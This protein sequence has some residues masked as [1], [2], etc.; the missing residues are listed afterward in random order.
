MLAVGGTVRATDMRDRRRAGR[1]RLAGRE[2]DPRATPGQLE[3]TVILEQGDLRYGRGHRGLERW[4]HVSQREVARTTLRQIDIGEQDERQPQ[5][6]M[7]LLA[8]RLDE[9]L[10]DDLVRDVVGGRRRSG[11]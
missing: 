1:K 4:I 9:G 3:T 11:K 2:R 6:E 7:D 8:V 5:H 10:D